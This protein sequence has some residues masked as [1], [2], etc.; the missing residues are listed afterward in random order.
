MRVLKFGGKSLDTKEKF[1]KICEYIKKIYQ[2]E[3]QI[4]VVVSAIGN[5]TDRLLNLSNNFGNNKN[6]NREL[7]VL[8]STGE[9]QS[10][11]LFSMHLN[12]IGVP[13]K[14]F[15]GSDIGIKTFGDYTSSV[16]SFVEKN[17]LLDIRMSAEVIK[18]LDSQIS[19]HLEID[20]CSS[21]ILGIVSFAR[22]MDDGIHFRHH[23]FLIKIFPLKSELNS[24]LYRVYNVKTI[25]SVIFS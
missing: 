1:S 4:I 18:Y 19:V 11:S 17:K 3:K 5:T 8:L 7:A 9:I 10:A 12:S 22:Q 15:C 6:S 16:I 24:I 2:N 20:V 23:T 25:D 14:S 21:L 13:A